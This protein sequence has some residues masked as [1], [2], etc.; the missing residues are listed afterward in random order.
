M[1]RKRAGAAG[2]TLVE[3][4]VTIVIIGIVVVS[5]FGLFVSLVHSTIIA[6]R[7]DTALTLATNQMEYLKSQPYDSLIVQSPTSTIKTLNG[8]NYTVK[9]TIK[10]IDDAY[11]GCGSGYNAA[12]PISVYCRNYPAPSGAPNPDLN[13]ADYKIAHVGVTD[14]SGANLASVDTEMAA[15]VSETASTTGALFV[16]IVDGSGAAV[17]GATVTVTNSTVTPNIN[18][19]DSSDSNGTVIFYG[20]TATHH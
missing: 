19:S 5:F 13:P 9:T 4:T 20:L 16:H 14:N 2:F 3:L 11:D 8:V 10:Y 7:R 18:K 15:R 17:S 6:K 1:D 12:T